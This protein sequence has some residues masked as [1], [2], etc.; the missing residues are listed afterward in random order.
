M[1]IDSPA[2]FLA[3]I[4]SP[5]VFPMTF[6]SPKNYSPASRSQ[7][8]NRFGLDASSDLWQQLQPLDRQS[9]RIS[10]F[11]PPE[12]PLPLL[13]RDLQVMATWFDRDDMDTIEAD[14]NQYLKRLPIELLWDEDLELL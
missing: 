6:S 4:V 3:E 5:N 2:Q 14:L 1:W 10:P 8:R 12:V 13:N 7:R 9:Y 11:K